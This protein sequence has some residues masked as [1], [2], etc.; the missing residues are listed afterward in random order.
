MGAARAYG[1]Q[2]DAVHGGSLNVDSAPG[3]AQVWD[4][5]AVAGTSTSRFVTRAPAGTATGTTVVRLSAD[6]FFTQQLGTAVL[7]PNSAA[8]VA[9]LVAQVAATAGGTAAYN[10][11]QYNTSIYTVPAGHKRVNVAY[12]DCQNI[13]YITPGLLD[14][15]KHFLDVPVPDNAVPATGTD[16]ELTVYDPAADQV[17]EFW[18]MAKNPTTGGWEACWGGRIDHAS[19]SNGQF[20]NPFGV[21]ASG[22]LMAAGTITL[23]DLRKG[24]ID[25]AMYLTVRSASTAFSFPATRT[26]GTSLAADAPMQGQ[27]F[28][29]DPSLDVTTLG[30]TPVGLM[31]ARAAQ[32]Y[33]FIVADTSGAVAVSGE[34]AAA[35][36]AV[37][38]VDPYLSLTPMPSY[39][40]LRGFPW[41]RMQAIAQDWG[42]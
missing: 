28:R 12:R 10:R 27:R 15:A 23:A 9:N 25:H 11:S 34:S 18:R 5:G 4:S 40:I 37:T 24:S 6:S 38:G 16:A 1:E 13:G 31:V 14:G 3:G 39:E 30:L 35:E 2:L 22:I 33:G 29:L 41:H 17:W 20:P 21:T 8:V 7:A 32:K 36:M 42:R 19:T 26:D